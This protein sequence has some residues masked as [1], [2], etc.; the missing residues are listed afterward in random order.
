[1]GT[2]VDILSMDEERARFQAYL[3]S[4]N[5]NFDFEVRDYCDTNECTFLNQYKKMLTGASVSDDGAG[6]LKVIIPSPFHMA[7]KTYVSQAYCDSDA[8]TDDFYF[9]EN[10]TAAELDGSF[11]CDTRH[12]RLLLLCH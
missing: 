11:Y 4:A 1:M 2:D 8:L 7:N 5:L 9:H 6:N 3:K 10:T 12:G